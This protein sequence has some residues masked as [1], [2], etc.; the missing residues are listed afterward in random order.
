MIAGV[1]AQNLAV[2]AKRFIGFQSDAETFTA[3]SLPLLTLYP[4][5][6]S[7]LSFCLGQTLYNQLTGEKGSYEL[8][9]CH[10]IANIIGFHGERNLDLSDLFE[11]KN[12]DDDEEIVAGI[13]SAVRRLGGLCAT[14]NIVS[15]VDLYSLQT[16]RDKKEALKLAPLLSM[17][18]DVHNYPP[19]L[20]ALSLLGDERGI[21]RW[22]VAQWVE[23]LQELGLALDVKIE[24]SPRQGVELYPM[25]MSPVTFFDEEI[26]LNDARLLGEGATGKVYNYKNKYAIKSI[27]WSEVESAI[28]EYIAL[29]ECRGDVIGV[30]D[31]QFY[32]DNS[33]RS[34]LS[35]QDFSLEKKEVWLVLDLADGDLLSFI[36]KDKVKE[37]WRR[38]LLQS[39]ANVHRRGICEL[40]VK[41]QNCLIR[42]GDL[43]ISDPGTARFF[44]YSLPYNKV[45]ISTDY[46]RDIRLNRH[47]IENALVMKRKTG[48]TLIFDSAPVEQHGEVDVYA[49]GLTLFEMEIGVMPTFVSFVPSSLNLYGKGMES[50]SY[51]MV[52][53]VVEKY[54]SIDFT[55][56]VNPDLRHLIRQMVCEDHEARVSAMQC[57]ASL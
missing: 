40:D 20:V 3:D 53:A 14:P 48:D 32:V 56:V 29:N 12:E 55:L 27:D 19:D 50:D 6:R 35:K 17:L 28:R 5:R 9:L 37:K 31:I 41:P 47:L 45:Q 43:F 7:P 21:I 51:A 46:Y 39:L 23:E 49:A 16:G 36:R 44:T 11:G 18:P 30:H 22:K 15:Y 54:E 1:I 4:K 57:L 13:I 42:D 24:E 34:E 25:R 10:Y 52:K 26:D 8:R 33:R 2:T 38:Q